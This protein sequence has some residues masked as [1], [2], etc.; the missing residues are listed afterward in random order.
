M[1]SRIQKARPWVAATRS[2][3]LMVRSCTGTG[4]RFRWRRCQWSP[5]SKETQTP[6]SVPAKRRPFRTGS[7]RTTRTNSPAWIPF[8]IRV[9]LFP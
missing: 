1:S 5:L 9:Q 3:S 6:R 7:S 4:G 8:T 2:P